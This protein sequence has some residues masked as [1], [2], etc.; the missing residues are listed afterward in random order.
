MEPMTIK[1][2]RILIKHPDSG[3][4][5]RAFIFIEGW[6]AR[7]EEVGTLREALRFIEN[8]SLGL[9]ECGGIKQIA[10]EALKWKE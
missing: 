9:Y 6:N 10:M 4:S 1:K 3:V 5:E 7:G 2:A 8:S